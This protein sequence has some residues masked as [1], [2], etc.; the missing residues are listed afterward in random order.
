[1]RDCAY[2]H[3]RDSR[4]FNDSFLDTQKGDGFLLKYHKNLDTNL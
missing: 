1:M 4:Q 2:D 3:R